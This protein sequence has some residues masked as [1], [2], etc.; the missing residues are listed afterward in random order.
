MEG[1]FTEGKLSGYGRIM[2]KEYIGEDIMV[3][4]EDEFFKVFILNLSASHHLSYYPISDT[5]L[6]FIKFHI[7]SFPQNPKSLVFKGQQSEIIYPNFLY[8][9]Y[10]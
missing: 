7:F 4:N 2:Y 3:L 8:K 1:T 5:N 6:Y 10:N 9:L